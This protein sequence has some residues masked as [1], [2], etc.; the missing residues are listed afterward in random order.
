MEINKIDKNEVMNFI[1]SI[2]KID[3]KE[4]MN[5]AK[6]NSSVSFFLF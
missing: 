4:T 6:Q 5:F 2:G 1:R 3:K